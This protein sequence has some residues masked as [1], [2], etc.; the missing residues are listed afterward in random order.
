MSNEVIPVYII[1]G[2]YYFSKVYNVHCLKGLVNKYDHDFLSF[3]QFG[4]V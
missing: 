3:C 4:N 2:H 1:S